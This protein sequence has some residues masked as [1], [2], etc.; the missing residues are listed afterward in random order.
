MLTR[1]KFKIMKQITTSNM[2]TELEKEKLIVKDD[3]ICPITNQHCDD[4]CCTVGSEC[5]IS[6][7]DLKEPST[8]L[9]PQSLI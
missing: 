8:E 3:M 1:I 4:E 6:G 9:T 7:D 2:Q 5:N